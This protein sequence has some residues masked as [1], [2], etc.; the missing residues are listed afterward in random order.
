MLYNK[1]KDDMKILIL[2]NNLLNS[3][4]CADKSEVWRQL[5]SILFVI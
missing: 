1:L 2:T 4:N 3:P 5:K